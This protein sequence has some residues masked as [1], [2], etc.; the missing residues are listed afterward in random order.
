MFVKD[1]WL[2]IGAWLT[3]GDLIATQLALPEI[4]NLL[5]RI[6]EIW[7]GKHYLEYI[8]IFNVYYNGFEPTEQQE[9]LY[10]IKQWNRLPICKQE[11]DYIIDGN[12]SKYFITLTCKCTGRWLLYD[13]HIITS[14]CRQTGEE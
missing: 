1:H 2:L 7:Y 4:S 6:P 12:L 11:R 14:E 5:D 3:K 8:G 10:K 13:I 9:A